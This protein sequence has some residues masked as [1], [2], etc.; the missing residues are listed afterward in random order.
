M[1]TLYAITWKYSD[2]SASGVVRVYETRHERLLCLLHH[3]L[4]RRWWP[5]KCQCGRRWKHEE[6]DECLPF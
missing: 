4:Y 6:T 1:D 2:N 5:Q 3:W